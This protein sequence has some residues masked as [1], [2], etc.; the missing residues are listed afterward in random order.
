[1]RK[2]LIGFIGSIAFATVS[3][4]DAAYIIKLKNGNEYVTNRYWHEGTQLLFDADG[5]VFGIDKAFVGKIEKTDKVIKLLTRTETSSVEKPETILKEPSNNITKDAPVA[6]S[7]TPR[8]KDESDPVYKEFSA[9]KA[10]SDSLLTM[11]SAELNEYVKQVVGL[12][13]KIQNE[14]KINQYRQE[15]SDLN[16]L[17]HSIEEAIKTRR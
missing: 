15:Y 10:R 4:A 1:M 6:A 14:R 9:L 3:G 13:S 8:T 7:K 11:S 5:G 16:A 2:A 17:A 12:I